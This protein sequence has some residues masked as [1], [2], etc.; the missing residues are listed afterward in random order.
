MAVNSAND[1][2][3]PDGDGMLNLMEFYLG[4]DPSRAGASPVTVSV[5]GGA[6]RMTQVLPVGVGGVVGTVEV[7]DGLQTWQS[8]SGVTSMVSDN[9]VGGSRTVVVRDLVPV[10]RRFMRLRVTR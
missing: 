3:D 2:A 4:T 5:V 1:G 9:V 6:L 10:G 7:S 8:G